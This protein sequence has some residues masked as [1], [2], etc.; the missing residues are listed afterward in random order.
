MAPAAAAID[1]EIEA[2]PVIG[3]GRRWRRR[4]V[5][6]RNG[7]VGGKSRLRRQ[8]GGNGK[9]SCGDGLDHRSG[10]AG[11]G[12]CFRGCRSLI[13]HYTNYGYLQ[14]TTSDRPRSVAPAV[15][16]YSIGN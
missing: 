13:R 14:L 7:Q 16:A 10:L 15:A 3:R 12:A 11:A 8:Q 6:R 2:A 1:A 9:A 5:E 4:L